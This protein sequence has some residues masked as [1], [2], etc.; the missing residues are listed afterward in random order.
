MPRGWQFV[1]MYCRVDVVVM[2]SDS[3][4]R[5]CGLDF[6]SFHFHIT[7]LDKLFT[8]TCLCHL[9]DLDSVPPDPSETSGTS[10]FHQL[11]SLATLSAPLQVTPVVCRSSLKW[12]AKFTVVF[13][14]QGS[15]PPPIPLSAI[16]RQSCSHC[17]SV[18]PT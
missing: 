10:F 17:L 12:S 4:L 11:R 14:I 5:A 3:Q 6:W 9:R 1:T 8:H 15:P 18:L 7:T 16:S 2:A 13:L